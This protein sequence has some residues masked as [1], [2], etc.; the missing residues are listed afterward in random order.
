[1][2]WLDVIAKIEE[3]AL[4][5]ERNNSPKLYGIFFRSDLIKDIR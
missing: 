5:E 4:L 2:A 1:M 3:F